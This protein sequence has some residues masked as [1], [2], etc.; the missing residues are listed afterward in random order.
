MSEIGNCKNFVT[1]EDPE[2]N[3]LLLGLQ[4]AYVKSRTIADKVQFTL[5][6]PVYITE[7]GKTAAGTRPSSIAHC[8][9]TWERIAEVYSGTNARTP[10]QFFTALLIHFKAG[11]SKRK[12]MLTD[13]MIKNAADVVSEYLEGNLMP[14]DPYDNPEQFVVDNNVT[15][16]FCFN[17]YERSHR[18]AKKI[19]YAMHTANDCPSFFRILMGIWFRK[20]QWVQD[21]IRGVAGDKKWESYELGKFMEEA[22]RYLGTERVLCIYE[23]M[24]PGTTAAVKYL[25]Q[26]NKGKTWADNFVWELPPL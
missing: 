8:I 13:F 11:G 22:E 18:G 23:N 14:Q 7:E 26:I 25:Y 12:L 21:C 1:S 16:D 5:P 6:R 9:K 3:M 20:H 10:E 17:V 4:A 15:I 19:D 2:E 24:T